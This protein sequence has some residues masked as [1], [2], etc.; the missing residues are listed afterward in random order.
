MLQDNGSEAWRMSWPTAMKKR[1]RTN[2]TSDSPQALHFTFAIVYY[3]PADFVGQKM[4]R[5]KALVI[6]SVISLQNLG[7]LL[8][9]R[10]LG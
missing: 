8:E 7:P 9:L 10:A 1:N 4:A 2:P 3:C 5:E 6:H